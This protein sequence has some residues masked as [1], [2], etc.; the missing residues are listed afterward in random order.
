VR[1]HLC[2]HHAYQTEYGIIIKGVRNVT[3][4]S[5]VDAHT[6]R[7]HGLLRLVLDGGFIETKNRPK[8]IKNQ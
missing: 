5:S 2:A 6:N 8:S 4:T 3:M 1:F 7:R